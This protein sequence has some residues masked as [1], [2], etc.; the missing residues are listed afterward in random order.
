MSSSYLNRVSSKL[1]GLP[2]QA[3]SVVRNI[4]LLGS[5]VLLLLI[6][7]IG[8]V[9]TESLTDVEEETRSLH[10]SET[11]HLRATL[12][13]RG[14]AGKI[15][16]EARSVLTLR[17]NPD[18]AIVKIAAEQNLKDLKREMDAAMA[19]ASRSL[20]ASSPQWEEFE[21][22]FD[23]YWTAVT[24]PAVQDW[25]AQRERMV[26][27][28]DSLDEM[29][30][31]KQQQDARLSAVLGAKAKRNILLATIIALA[32][33][34]TVT[35]LTFYEIRRTLDRLGRAYEQS[36]ESRDY[37]QSLLDS[38]TSGVVVIARDGRLQTVSDS[39]RAQTGLGARAAIGESYETLFAESP[40][41]V[42]EIKDR[43]DAVT[44]ES[45]YYDRLELASGRVF[46]VFGSPLL[47][48]GEYRGLIVVFVDVTEAE[49]ARKELRR[50][51]AL[52]AVGQMTAQIAHEI[53]NP[54]GS[55]RFATEML[56]RQTPKGSNGDETD[57]IGVID[58]S[59]NH[60]A[61]IVSELSEFARPKELNLSE[62]DLHQLL[63]EL[64]PMVADRLTAKDVSIK[65]VY[66]AAELRGHYDLTELRKLF[67]NLIIN[68]IDASE[69]GDTLEVRTALDKETSAVVE[70][71]DEGV[72][73]DAETLRRLFEPFYTTKKTGTGLGMAIAKKI[74]ELHKGDLSVRSRLGEGTT[75]AV[76]LPLD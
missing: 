66:H 68:A 27:A 54:L 71:A 12:K 55:I 38:L 39:F 6:A 62:V 17:E 65:K 43:L 60:L 76:R 53:K 34:L 59:V 44:Q 19:D 74:A 75:V 9:S 7:V 61:A 28:I 24:S 50:N 29:V 36:A 47:I 15:E 33:G 52:S 67:L 51:R 25:Y 23:S 72:G 49:K 69:A 30:I 46:D 20:L 58:R 22:A 10:Q 18:L 56:K 26:K 42:D 37:L 35:G 32:V 40:Q 13:V 70:V 1:L 4:L 16:T 63:D 48:A 8:Y 31:N 57:V 3:E 5:C 2:L 73:M 45:H 41:L 64:V 21:A 14:I 11:N